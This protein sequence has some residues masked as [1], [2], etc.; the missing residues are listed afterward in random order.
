MP[1]SA[2]IEASVHLWSS[3]GMIT[4][5]SAEP[6]APVMVRRTAVKATC[7]GLPYELTRSA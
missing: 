5:A 3:D 7:S 1:Y 2:K 4:A 6:S